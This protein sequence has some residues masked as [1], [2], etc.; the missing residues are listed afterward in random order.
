PI[1][2]VPVYPCTP[3]SSPFIFSKTPD[4]SYLHHLSFLSLH[5]VHYASGPSRPQAFT[6]RKYAPYMSLHLH[7]RVK[8]KLFF[9]SNCRQLSV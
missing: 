4:L 9:C 2:N 7:Q 3:P 5:F 1:H 6:G 8:C